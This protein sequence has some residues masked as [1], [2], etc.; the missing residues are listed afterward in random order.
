MTGPNIINQP[1]LVEL[2]RYWRSKFVGRRLPSR[3]SI[4]PIEIPKLLPWVFMMDVEHS[5]LSFRYRLIGTGI[6]GFLGRDFTGRAVD[7]ANYGA[8]AERMHAIFRSAVDRR[9]ATA[10]RGRLFYVPSKSFLHVCWTMMPLSTD[11]Q[12]IDMLFCGYSPEGGASSNGDPL[13]METTDSEIIPEP[14]F[15]VA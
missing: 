2:H 11:G 14:E 8:R 5:P 3:S 6:V 7:E 13:T 12:T 10:V 9:D 1:I 4:D 15:V